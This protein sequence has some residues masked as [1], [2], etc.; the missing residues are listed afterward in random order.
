ML[1]MPC[2]RSVGLSCLFCFESQQLEAV[3]LSSAS[4]PSPSPGWLLLGTVPGVESP[5]ECSVAP[6]K[7]PAALGIAGNGF[8]SCCTPFPSQLY[9][10]TVFFGQGLQQ[11]WQ[12]V[13]SG[14]KIQGQPGLAL[15]IPPHNDTIGSHPGCIGKGPET[16]HLSPGFR[17]F[18]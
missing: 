16:L 12:P 6:E 14:A 10:A 9:L 1:Q 4:Q 7:E 11:P 17:G 13:F 15:S 2:R 3:S 8:N 5:A 18:F